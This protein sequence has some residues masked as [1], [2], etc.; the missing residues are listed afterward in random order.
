MKNKIIVGGSLLLSVAANAE[1]SYTDTMK[2]SI[3][4]NG[5]YLDRWNSQKR[6]VDSGIIHVN[7]IPLYISGA[8]AY[9]RFFGK[10]S[11]KLEKIVQYNARYNPHHMLYAID[12]Q[13]EF[14]R[15]NYGNRELLGK[16]LIAEIAEPVI[17]LGADHGIEK[18]ADAL[19]KTE[20]G[21]SISQIIPQ[22][23]HQF[24]KKNGKI[25][26]AAL[27]ARSVGTVAK[28]ESLSQNARTFGQ[29]A[30]VHLGT[31]TLEEY[32]I[33]PQIDKLMGSEDSDT[34]ECAKFAANGFAMYGLHVGLKM[35]SA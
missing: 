3:D 18:A 1:L 27:A 21:K 23:H 22:E 5:F 28:D 9:L 26:L 2:S 15:Y 32:V 20:M 17:F 12:G 31:N 4:A 33:N 7:S 16:A 8:N 19:S 25:F 35:L 10:K 13:G 30:F 24:V 6:G 14:K 11:E 29:N 34:K